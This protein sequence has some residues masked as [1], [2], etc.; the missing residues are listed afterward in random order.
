MGKFKGSAGSG[1]GRASCLETRAEHLNEVQIILA[2]SDVHTRG[3]CRLDSVVRGGR[4]P[5]CWLPVHGLLLQRKCYSVPK[6]P[7]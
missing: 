3:V 4:I 5:M 6:L 1:S 7:I 2:S